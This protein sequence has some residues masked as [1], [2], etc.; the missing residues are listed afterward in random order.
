MR[1]RLIL[2]EDCVQTTQLEVG[3]GKS[4]SKNG[5]M[6]GKRRGKCSQDEYREVDPGK[7]S[8]PQPCMVPLGYKS[9]TLRHPMCSWAGEKA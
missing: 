1:T 8:P 2:K 6:K 7:S 5:S 4:Q 3:R 9:A